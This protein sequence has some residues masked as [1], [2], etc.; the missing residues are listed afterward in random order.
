VVQS[1]VEDLSPVVKKVSVELTPDRVKDALDVA[2]TSVS[3]T[4]KLKGYRQGHVPR[5]L[6]ERYFGDD[7]KKDVA[8]K[9]VTGSIHEALAEHRLDPVAPPR[10]ENGSVEVGQ[11]FK[12]TATVEVRPHVEPKDYEGLSVPKIDDAV[13]DPQVD[14]RIEEMRTGQAMFVPVEGREVVEGGDFVSADYEG[15]MGGAPLRGAKREGVLLEAA[16]GSLLENKAEALLGSRV[17]E[18]REL[19]VT[20]PDDYAAEELRGK[21]A[22]FQ[23]AVKGLKKREVPALDDAFVQDLGGEAKTVDDLRA[24]VRLDLAQQKKQRAESEQREAV[25]SALV[26]KNPIE[27]PPALV[28]RNVDAM[29][30]GM[31]EGF[32]RRG[33]DPRQLGLNLDRMRDELRQRA[34]LE[35][36]GYLLLES[37][38]EKEKIDATEEDLAKHFEK[39][40][41][42]LKQP[43]DKI[44]AAFRKQDSLDS[45]RARLRQDKA[46]AFLLSKATFQ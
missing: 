38:A 19:S 37:I 6:V 11:P 7:V 25:L 18:T 20:F 5:R 10:V 13:A 34:L 22:R 44:R 26:A 41:G 30:Q 40:S 2:Y 1:R 46:L 36:K 43:A 45:L 33:I 4:V 28:E 24:K 8:Q 39:L 42:E 16:P 23:V 27:A 35:V 31:L 3:R 17:G 9:L 29:L 14:E 21:E 12:Y 32:M 15:F